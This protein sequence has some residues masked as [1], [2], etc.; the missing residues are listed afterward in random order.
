MG[1]FVHLFRKYLHAIVVP[2]K[3][4]AFTDE[5]HLDSAVVIG[6][7]WWRHK[8]RRAGGPALTIR[9]ADPGREGAAIVTGRNVPG[10]L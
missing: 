7:E 3:A 9:V 6:G 8:R 2:P 10:L 5:R 1:H 4:M